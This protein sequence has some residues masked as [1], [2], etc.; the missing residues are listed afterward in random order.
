[1]AKRLTDSEAR[2]IMIDAGLNPQVP[3]ESSSLPWISKCL[4]CN[5]EVSPNFNSVKS[6]GTGC[7]F[8]SGN[9]VHPDDALKVME[10]AKL[11]PLTKFPGAG[12]PWKSK[13]LVCGEIVTPRYKSVRTNGGGC[14]Y[15]GRIKAGLSN[16]INEDEASKLEL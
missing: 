1:M 4:K 12:K 8:C 15:C 5:R 13:C 2:R 6:K 3:F 10:K 7:A 11:Q 9:A 14:K 16:R